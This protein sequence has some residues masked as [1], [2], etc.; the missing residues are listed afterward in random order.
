MKI[1]LGLVS[2]ILIAGSGFAYQLIE[3]NQLKEDQLGDYRAQV[4]QLLSATEASSRARLEYEKQI[5]E[6]QSEVNT[7]SSQ[8]TAV[9]NQLLTAQQES[10]DTRA[11]E[12]EIRQRVIAEFQQQRDT[13]TSVSRTNLARQLALMDPTERNE[14]ISMQKRYGNFLSSLDVSDERMDVIIG[15]LGN[16]IATENQERTAIMQQVK[17]GEVNIQDVRDQML[18]IHDQENQLSALSYVLTE[19]ELSAFSD[20]QE[21]QSTS[22]V[23]VVGSPVEGAL[24]DQTFYI[25]TPPGGPLVDGELRVF[26]VEPLPQ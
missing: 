16:V 20:Y 3:Q 6:L 13:G 9:S 5:D 7:L 10:P 11:L 4:S 12:Q 19:E 23:S 15:A 21:T 25:G 24:Q 2:A 14:F 18:G 26:S 1:I 17:S 8:L 22:R